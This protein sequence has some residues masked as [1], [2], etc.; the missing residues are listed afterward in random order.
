MTTLLDSFSPTH[1]DVQE[2][3][4]LAWEYKA[5]N[6]LAGYGIVGALTAWRVWT[7]ARFQVFISEP[8]HRY[9]VTMGVLIDELSDLKQ[10][11][12]LDRFGSFVDEESYEAT[13]ERV[14]YA[15]VEGGF[16]VDVIADTDDFIVWKCEPNST[17]KPAFLTRF[18][19]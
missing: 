1:R 7:A 4:Q 11:V 17:Q 2:L 6:M 10:L 14:K 3:W 8:K 9:L 18:V 12:V 15:Y 16:L 13:K 5:V 19:L